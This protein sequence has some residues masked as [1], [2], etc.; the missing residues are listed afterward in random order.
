MQ[1]SQKLQALRKEKGMSQEQLAEQIGVSRQAVSKW[2]LGE[3]SPDIDNIVQLSTALCVTTDYLLKEGAPRTSGVAAQAAAAAS[4]TYTGS[5]ASAKQ[6]QETN[7]AIVYISSVAFVVIGLLCA[8]ASY[9]DKQI[10][11]ALVGGMILQSV[12]VVGYFVAKQIYRTKTPFIITF[13]QVAAVSFLPL[14]IALHRLFRNFPSPYP[15]ALPMLIFAVLYP[16]LLLFFALWLRHREKR[17]NQHN[18]YK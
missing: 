12:G 14:A 9:Y 2:E 5:G 6:K 15:G 11:E 16:V 18:Q 17:Q 7:A 4:E 1:L 8:L 10:G 13:L 3:S